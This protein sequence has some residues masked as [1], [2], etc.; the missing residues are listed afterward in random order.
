[1]ANP[2]KLH[3]VSINAGVDVEKEFYLGAIATHP[4]E[5]I[6]C[7]D[8]AE[9]DFVILTDFSEHEHFGRVQDCP[10]VM[11]YPEKSIIIS[12]CDQ[13]VEILP[14]FYSSGIQSS[15]LRNFMEGWHF[16]FLNVRFPNRQIQ[17]STQ[18]GSRERDFLGSF[19]G[20]PSHTLRLK[21]AKKFG[22]FPDM[23]IKVSKEYHH[24]EMNMDM[25]SETPQKRYVDMLRNSHFSLCPRGR[26][27]SSMRLYDSMR[28]GVVPVIISDAW[29]KPS[30]VDWD[31]CSLQVK[32]KHLKELHKIL[33]EHEPYSNEMGKTAKSVYQN[34][35]ADECLVGTLKRTLEQMKLSL[36]SPPKISPSF[37][38]R[39]R[40]SRFIAFKT[41]F[42]KAVLYNRLHNI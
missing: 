18:E 8:P 35:F 40:M 11:E 15:R 16:P 31:S 14:G 33:L 10:E 4:D 7:S 2:L 24:F 1:M 25:E 30:F 39:S 29:V 34:Y 41:A 12:E 20:Y 9:A 19:I 3:F 28:F 21:L 26:G 5:L 6:A 36:Q 23:S 42:Y 13:P 22:H 37:V 38:L 17:L 32:E 27:P